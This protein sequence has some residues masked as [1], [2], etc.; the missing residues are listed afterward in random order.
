MT[1]NLLFDL[2]IQS[3]SEFKYINNSTEL[4]KELPSFL[5]AKE[6]GLDIETTGLD[7]HQD[8]IRLLQLSCR[9]SSNLVIDAYAVSNWTELLKPLF[10]LNTIKI[11]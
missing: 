8:H 9:G 10:R 1:Y 6:I 7:P 5:A 11:I 3:K 4:E 2:P